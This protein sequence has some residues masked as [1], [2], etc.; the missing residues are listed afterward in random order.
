MKSRFVVTKANFCD[1]YTIV[2]RERPIN[3]NSPTQGQIK[4]FHGSN[5]TGETSMFRC[6]SSEL[7]GNSRISDKN[8]VVKGNALNN[9]S[10]SNNNSNYN[11]NN[12][13]IINS[14][15]F[16]LFQ[17]VSLPLQLENKIH[18]PTKTNCND[19]NGI[20]IKKSG[21]HYL[22][23]NTG[24]SDTTCTN[25]TSDSNRNM[26]NSYYNNGNIQQFDNLKSFNN[27]NVDL[28]GEIGGNVADMSSWE[29]ALEYDIS[30]ENLCDLSISPVYFNY[31]LQPNE[32]KKNAIPILINTTSAEEYNTSTDGINIGRSNDSNGGCIVVSTESVNQ[33]RQEAKR[34]ET[35]QQLNQWKR[36]NSQ[37]KKV[38][39]E[40]Q[41]GTNLLLAP[42]QTYG[43]NFMLN[44][45]ISIPK[46]V[47]PGQLSELQAVQSLHS[48]N[49]SL[50]ND[51][52]QLSSFGSLPQRLNLLNSL[53]SFQIQEV[54]QKQY[55][56][57]YRAHSFGPVKSSAGIISDIAAPLPSRL[58]SKKSNSLVPTILS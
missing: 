10:G 43:E 57:A 24:H 6:S 27:V 35:L 9:Y 12:N 16:R 5:V 11:N 56:C 26:R 4:P 19:Y 41:R 23:D 45:C 28:I 38:K 34:L 15:N 3:I 49:N 29:R 18:N 2:L 7:Y 40:P 25:N 21:N 44:P 50:V 52:I 1:F 31:D 58:V 30:L 39:A 42:A 51:S 36:R 32:N 20:I 17:N 46:R 55:P 33:Q 13:A 53:P 14:K 37:V 54:A 8:K 47:C 48:S 22:N